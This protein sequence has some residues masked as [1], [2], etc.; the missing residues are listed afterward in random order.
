MSKNLPGYRRFSAAL[1]GRLAVSKSHQNKG[2]GELLLMD[3]FRRCF[4]LE[5]PVVVIV[6]DPK[7]QGVASWYARYGF[8]PLTESRMVVTLLELKARFNELDSH[9]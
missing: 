5:V 2:L 4:S 6:V 9:H 7:N 1:L 3:A 8:R